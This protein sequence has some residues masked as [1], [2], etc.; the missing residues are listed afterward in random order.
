[1]DGVVKAWSD[2][3][4]LTKT[5]THSGAVDIMNDGISPYCVLP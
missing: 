2:G 1:M 5:S 3:K 4:I